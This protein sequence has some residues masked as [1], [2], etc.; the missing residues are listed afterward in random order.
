M[1]T[2]RMTDQLENVEPIFVKLTQ[3]KGPVYIDATR[4][5]A[6][7]VARS[8]DPQFKTWAR[9]YVALEHQCFFYVRETPEE[10]ARLLAVA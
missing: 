3:D 4:V 1:E 8:N 10:V 5:L 2:S 9:A 6:V 7:S